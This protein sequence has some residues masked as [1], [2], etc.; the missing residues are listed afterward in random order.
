[1]PFLA[2]VVGSGQASLPTR[3]RVHSLGGGSHTVFAVGQGTVSLGWQRT[4][5]DL[6]VQRRVVLIVDQLLAFFAAA[7]PGF[8]LRSPLLAVDPRP[9]CLVGCLTIH[10]AAGTYPEVAHRH[11][12]RRAHRSSAS[13]AAQANER[14]PPHLIQ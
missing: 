4:L 3:G 14:R 9:A 12:P 6:V 5:A 10:V 7:W 11:E 13:L 8:G 2:V 1:M